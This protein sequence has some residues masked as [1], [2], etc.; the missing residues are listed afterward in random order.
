MDAPGAAGADRRDAGD[1]GTA[2]AW[3]PDTW[4]DWS[5]VDRDKRERRA[6]EVAVRARRAEAGLAH[7][8][9]MTR[10]RAA[11]LRSTVVSAVA[12]TPVA[13]A[14]WRVLHARDAAIAAG[15]GDRSFVPGG[16]AGI[17][18]TTVVVV[19]LLRLWAATLRTH[20]GRLELEVLPDSPAAR[21]HGAFTGTTEPPQRW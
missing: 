20:P 17:V 10:F 14:W 12:L 3:V 2:A 16:F 6:V 7:E 9:A 5:R 11:L 15:L 1:G 19:I 18:L 4:D 13:V 8:R 21:R